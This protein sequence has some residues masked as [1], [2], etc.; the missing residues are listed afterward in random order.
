VNP[1]VVVYSMDSRKYEKISDLGV[2]RGQ[3]SFHGM[4]EWLQD[5]RHLIAVNEND[6]FL[7]DSQT[8]ETRTLFTVPREF[9]VTWMSYAS[10]SHT[11]FYS[12][13]ST[14]SDIWLM[15]LK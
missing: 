15:K 6:I 5:N 8:K 10:L 14:E 9:T 1:G 4:P 3:L 7:L 11:I 12:D 2:T 13:S